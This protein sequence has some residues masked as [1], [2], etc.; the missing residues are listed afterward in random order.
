MYI[1]IVLLINLSLQYSIFIY[2]VS[3]RAWSK[4][5]KYFVELNISL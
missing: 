2:D 1:L 5:N 4:T 3:D